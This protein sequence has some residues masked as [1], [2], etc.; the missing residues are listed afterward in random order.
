MRVSFADRRQAGR[1][2]A[3][4]LMRFA[5]RRPIVVALPRGGVP[6]AYEVSGALGAPLDIV[7]VR[8]IGAPGNPELGVGAIAEDGTVVID[9]RSAYRVGMSADMLEIAVEREARE[10]A[11][12]V[13]CYREG[14][15]RLDVAGRIVIA[16]DDGLATGL[17][18]IA[19][20]RA[21]REHGAAQVIVAVPVGVRESVAR[22]ASEAD[23]VVCHTTPRELGGVGSWYQDFS[24]VTDDEVVALLAAAAG[25]SA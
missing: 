7:A 25:R 18:D 8:K 15:E 17:S 3:G 12:R 4:E 21:L 13:A 16:V 19:A 1:L 20:V 23:G 24:A 6:V 11:R 10:L 9:R 14:R 22:V 2:L 5:A